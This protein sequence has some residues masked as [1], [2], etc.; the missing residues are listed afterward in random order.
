[1]GQPKYA[2]LF[3]GRSLERWHLRCLAEL[4]VHAELVGVIASPTANGAGPASVRLSR[5]HYARRLTNR[6]NEDVTSRFSGT[7]SLSLD[8]VRSDVDFVLRL[9]GVMIPEG[10]A[11]ASPQGV[12]Y[13]EHESG[14]GALPFLDEVYDAEDVTRAALLR[15]TGV[16]REV[17]VLE[18]GWFPTNKLSYEASRH[19]VEDAVAAWPGRICPRLTGIGASSG[20]V[21]ETLARRSYGRTG[22]SRLRA[23]T[24]LRR[25]ARAWERLFRHPQW[26]IG[27]LRAPVSALLAPGAYVDSEVEWFP[28]KGREGFLADPFAIARAG[29]VDVLCEYYSYRDSKGD[30][31]ALAYS[32]PG[33]TEPAPVM[34]SASHM[35]YPFLLEHAGE[36]YCIPETAALGEV[37]LYR[38]DEFPSRWSRIATLVSDFR[39]LDPTIFPHEGKWWLMCTRS[40]PHEDTELWAWHAPDLL[41]PW[42]GHSG[43]PVKTDVRGARP[44]GRPFVLDGALYRPGQDCSKTYGGRITLHR[45]TRLTPSEF[46]E[47]PVSVVEASPTNRFPTGPHTLTV[48]GDAVLLDGRRNVFAPAAL[49]AFLRIWAADLAG[50]RARRAS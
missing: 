19:R 47:E 24:T 38:A 37:A 28:L 20:R 6:L 5:H 39:G 3:D 16:S 30:I 1:M 25:L 43:N 2:L 10:L 7:K 18:E 36:T 21:R 31:R 26:C 33:F 40:G 46:A 50:G 27:V 41:G 45:V 14:D 32:N 9:G 34:A 29:R 35:S 42:I 49:R 4:D 11:A 15:V 12:L 23:L 44:G 13:F 8:D 17:E 22:L 48:I